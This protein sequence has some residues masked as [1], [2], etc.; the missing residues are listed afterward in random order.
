MST[1]DTFLN[2]W[3]TVSDKATVVET[4]IGSSKS[5][6]FNNVLVELSKSGRNNVLRVNLLTSLVKGKGNAS[7]FIKWLNGQADKHDFVISMCAQSVSTAGQESDMKK[8][9]LVGWVK[10]HGFKVRYEYPDEA[11]VEVARVPGGGRLPNSL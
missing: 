3:N 4:T 6:K 1:V 7:S 5:R 11:G 9:Q 10:R 2:H 8:D